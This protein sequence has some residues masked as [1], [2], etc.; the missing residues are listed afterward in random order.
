M[1]RDTFGAIFGFKPENWRI[2]DFIAHVWRAM[3]AITDKN[4]NVLYVGYECC[5]SSRAC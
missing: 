4:Y 5:W 2:H 3:D 1:D